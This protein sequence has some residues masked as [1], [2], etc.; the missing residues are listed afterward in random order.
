MVAFRSGTATV[1][2]APACVVALLHT[3]ARTQSSI[4]VTGDNPGAWAL[5]NASP[6]ILAQLQGN[7]FSAARAWA[8]RD[9][10]IV[11]IVLCDGQVDHTTGLLHVARGH[12]AMAAVV[13]R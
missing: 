1:A 10:A 4:A 7:P 2:T 3:R 12:A 13:Y 6:D 8:I 9:T 11:G 5:V